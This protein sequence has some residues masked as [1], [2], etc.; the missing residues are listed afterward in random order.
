MFKDNDAFDLAL[1]LYHWLQHNWNGQGDV[2]YSDFCALTEHYHP[3]RS[4]QLF[5]NID[6]SAKEVYDSLTNDNYSEALTIVLNYE[7]QG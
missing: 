2:K 4:E 3:S 6:E 7:S 5:D 1:D